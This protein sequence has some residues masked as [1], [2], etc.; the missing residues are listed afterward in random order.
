MLNDGPGSGKT[1]LT[2]IIT[3]DH[4]LTYSQPI[5][6]FSR[7]RL[8]EPGRRPV[9]LFDIQGRIGL[10]SPEL[11]SFF[12]RE[13]SLRRCVYSG[14]A[15]TPLSSPKISPEEHAHVDAALAEFSDLVPEG[16]WGSLFG[17][18][19]MSTQRLA[20]FLRAT[21]SKRDLVVYDEAFSG[22]RTDVRDRCFAFLE[23]ERGFDKQRQ[24][25]IVVSRVSD[26]VPPGVSRWVRLGENGGK[27]GAVFGEF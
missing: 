17:E 18:S 13:L 14:F 1:T 3:S 22:M 24:A 11:H 2:A 5:K 19:D 4:P 10:S 12:P 8:P 26:E 27:E 6:H 21:L 23:T 7:S 15:D 25:M 20:L 9:S 16:D